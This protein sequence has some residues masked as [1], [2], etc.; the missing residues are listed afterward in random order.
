MA[1]W[2][3]Y[4]S[5]D[6]LWPAPCRKPSEFAISFAW[7]T[8]ER[9]FEDG[10]ESSACFS[11]EM[12]SGH[13]FSQPKNW[14]ASVAYTVTGQSW[15]IH[16]WLQTVGFQRRI[17]EEFRQ[18]FAVTK[19]LTMPGGTGEM[20]L[21]ELTA[22]WLKSA[23]L[24]FK[25]WTLQSYEMIPLCLTDS[26]IAANRQAVSSRLWWAGSNW[27]TRGCANHQTYQD[28]PPQICPEAN[29]LPLGMRRAGH[30]T[31]SLSATLRDPAALQLQG[32]A[33]FDDSHPR[34]CLV[35]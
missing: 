11:R 25:V 31:N 8:P 9:G 28:F 14:C 16:L 33:S 35:A 3:F 19:A 26:L 22:C 1:V 2:T 7:G 5:D 18:N 30:A 6:S 29:I 17:P 20:D 32:F 21:A 24:H 4:D 34:L 27:H 15:S 10:L 12:G 23:S 13:S